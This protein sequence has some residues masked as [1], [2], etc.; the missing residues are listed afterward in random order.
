MRQLAAMTV[1][2]VQVGSRI[3]RGIVDL[4]RT[5]VLFRRQIEPTH[6]YRVVVRTAVLH[7]NH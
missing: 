6:A 1:A 3:I 7:I 4:Q 5:E 2:V